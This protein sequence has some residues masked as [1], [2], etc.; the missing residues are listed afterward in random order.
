MFSTS[1]FNYPVRWLD[2]CGAEATVAF[3]KNGCEITETK[4]NKKMWNGQ[5]IFPQKWMLLCCRCFFPARIPKRDPLGSLGS[6]YLPRK[7]SRAPDVLWDFLKTR[8]RNEDSLAH[9]GALGDHPAQVSWALKTLST[10]CKYRPLDLYISIHEK[11]SQLGIGS[12]FA[13]C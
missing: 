10:Y 11:G 5:L 1:P 9:G 7:P 4:I 8:G 2:P 13:T 3:P 6:S 12:K